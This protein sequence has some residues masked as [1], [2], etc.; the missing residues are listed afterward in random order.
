MTREEVYSACQTALSKNNVL[1]LEAATGLGKT[2]LSIMLVNWLVGTAWQSYRPKMLLLV[3][4]TVHK[5][6]WKDEFQKWGGIHCDVVMECYESLHK[7]VDETFDFIVMDEVHHIK[8]D[9]RLELL[10]TLKYGYMLGL[11]ATIPRNLKSY[12]KYQYHAQVVS[13]DI[14][15]AIEDEVLPEPEILLYPLTLDN[16]V[17][18][19]SWELNPRTKGP[20]VY[21]KYSDLWKIKKQKVHAIISCTQKQK[22]NE[23]NSEIDWYNKRWK[24]THNEALKQIWLH[25]CGQ[26]LEYYADI[27]L[28]IVRGILKHLQKYRTITFC[29]TINQA[30][31]AGRWCIHSKNGKDAEKF[32]NDFNARKLNHI[33]AV[34]ILNENANLV[35]CKYAIFCNISASEVIV[36]QRIGR[37]MRH[38]K[39]VIIIPFY[40]GTRE[41]EL[42]EKQLADFDKDFIRVIHSIE[43]I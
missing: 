14:V 11:S 5:Q 29:K 28:P 3:A 32:Y 43:E 34:N 24:A 17:P 2:R 18:S 36:P 16:V 6:T 37:S 41:E 30:E 12:F 19:E 20:T 1:L 15:E 9:T 4:K 23:Y 22:S 39:P 42:V 8:S 21:G 25:K 33:T 10:K 38:K 35:D 13:C 27:K 40:K 26:R 31:Q 7:H